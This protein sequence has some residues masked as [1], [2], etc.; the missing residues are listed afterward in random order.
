MIVITIII[1]IATVLSKLL[2][3]G[4]SDGSMVGLILSSS[5]FRI[6]LVSH[7]ESRSDPDLTLSGASPYHVICAEARILFHE[8]PWRESGSE[9]VLYS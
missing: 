8:T 4:T 3:A 2:K 6:I 5:R 1:N 7:V 9:A